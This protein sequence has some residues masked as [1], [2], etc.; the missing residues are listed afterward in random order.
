MIEQ[1]IDLFDASVTAPVATRHGLAILSNDG[2]MRQTGQGQ[3][4]PIVVDNEGPFS[5]WRIG[6]IKSSPYDLFTCG[7]GALQQVPRRLVLLLPN[8]CGQRDILLAAGRSVSST[9]SESPRFR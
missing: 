6:D 1:L 4:T 7:M 8:E 3:Y 5:Y 2:P 9:T